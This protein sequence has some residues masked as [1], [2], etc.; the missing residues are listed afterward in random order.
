MNPSLKKKLLI[1]AVS[2]SITLL[3]ILL[4]IYFS[5]TE[6]EGPTVQTTADDEEQ[7]EED[8][9]VDET[10]EP[11]QELPT[12]DQLAVENTGLDARV[13]GG[14]T[15]DLTDV[16][17]GE[18]LYG[19]SFNTNPSGRVYTDVID[20]RFEMYAVFENLPELRDGYF[21]EGWLVRN[22]APLGF[23][24][25]GAVT[26]YQSSYINTFTSET[27]YTS[28]NQYVLTI[29]PGDGNPAPDLHIVE[30]YFK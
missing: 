7:Q 23:I 27:D 16:T 2:V 29:E 14:L 26:K 30:G 13:L 25:T 21:Y 18:T 20:G 5:S 24:S 8:V 17:R 28:Y 3:S 1:G 19:F 12:Y 15:G 4:M 10:V 11:E 22:T 6:V 9:E